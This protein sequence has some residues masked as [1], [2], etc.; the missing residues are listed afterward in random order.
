MSAVQQLTFVE[1][2]FA[3]FKNRMNGLDDVYIAIF[4][5][6]AEGKSNDTVLIVRNTGSTAY[7]QNKGLDTNGDGKITKGGSIHGA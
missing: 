6:S 4:M 1:K 3:P 2:Y 7:R 5:P